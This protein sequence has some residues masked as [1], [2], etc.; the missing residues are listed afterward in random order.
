MRPNFYGTAINGGTSNFG[1]VFK[2][3]STGA[4]TILYNFNGPPGPSAVMSGLVLDTMGDLYGTS[5]FG[6]SYNYGTIY[7][8]DTTGAVTV[9]YSFTGGADG[10]TPEAGLVQDAGGNFYGTTSAG[11]AYN[12]GTVFELD[13]SGKETVLYTF[14]GGADGKSPFAGLIL[15]P[16]GNL[17]GTT[18]NGGTLNWGTVFMVAPSGRKIVLHSFAGGT[19]GIYPYASVIRD[20]AGNLYG[21]T[22]QGGIYGYGTV[23]RVVAMSTVVTKHKKVTDFLQAHN[24]WWCPACIAGSTKLSQTSVCAVLRQIK[25]A[26]RYYNWEEWAECKGCGQMRPGIRFT[27]MSSDSDSS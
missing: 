7:K 23:F 10:A 2:L 12:S 22:Q 25:M 24:D 13:T 26:I 21:T 4:E 11:G 19:D 3:D 5:A 9:L 18:V 1:C 17:Y 14:T 16:A 6:G 15:D 27:E 20:S 8:L